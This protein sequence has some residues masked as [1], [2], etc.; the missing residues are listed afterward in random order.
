MKRNDVQLGRPAVLYADTKTNIEAITGLVGG[1]VAYA[2]DTGEDGVYDAV[3]A[4]WVWGRAGSSAPATTAANDFQV[5]NGAGGWVKKTLAETITILRTSLDSVYAILLA[6]TA[7]NDFQVGNGSGG[8]IKKTLAEVKTILG[9]GTAAYTAS[10]DY[11]VAAKGVTNG[12]SHDHSGGDGA[13]IAGVFTPY[14]SAKDIFRCDS[15]GGVSAFVGTIATLP[16][17]APT[18]LTYNITSG[19]EGALVPLATTHLAKLRLYNTTRGTNAL[20][21]NCVV[22]TNTITLTANVPA[23]WTVGDTIS[24]ASPTVSGAGFSWIDFEITDA[25]LLSKSALAVMFVHRSATAGDTAVL[26]PTE[27]Y[28]A[29]K[30]IANIT[31]AVNITNWVGVP[32]IVVNSDVFSVAWSGSP[33][34]VYARIQGYIS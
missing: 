26:H 11:A 6:S 10:T 14:T 21:S 23:G 34:F 27:A 12:D 29:G 24:I 13:A 16:G 9:L 33:T 32:A 7:S 18:T 2:T 5:G 17:G 15:P 25:T 1:E 22:G 20:I 31:Q 28:G 3:G 30:I 19:Q 4:A 8:W